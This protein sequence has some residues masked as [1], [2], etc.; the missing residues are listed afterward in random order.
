M[1][2]LKKDGPRK[3]ENGHRREEQQKGIDADCRGVRGRDCRT[4]ENGTASKRWTTKTF[5]EEPL[6]QRKR[7]DTNMRVML[8]PRR[9][10]FLPETIIS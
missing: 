7:P 10:T 8:R 4:S 9:Y 1:E 5:T 6:G 2:R 3:Y